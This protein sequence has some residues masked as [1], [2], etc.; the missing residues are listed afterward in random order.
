VTGTFH[1]LLSLLVPVRF[2]KFNV[3]KVKSPEGLT[4]VHL[5]CTD[6]LEFITG[7]SSNMS[8]TKR[9]DGTTQSNKCRNHPGDVAIDMSTY[10]NLYI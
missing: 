1:V 8:R 4:I 9:K 10:I 3:L 5:T 6:K 7:H 2:H